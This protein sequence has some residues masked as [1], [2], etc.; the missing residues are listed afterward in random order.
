[1]LTV[2]PQ[3][4]IVSF[5]AGTIPTLIWLWF[6]VREEEKRAEP[7]GLLTAVFV[8]GMASVMF[9][10]PIQ[11]FIQNTIS[12]HEWQ[13]TLWAASEEII[14]YL[15]VVLVLYGT[16]EIDEP[17]DW[18]I[19]MITAGLGFAALENTFFLIKP[20]SLGDS[21]VGLLTG[22][23]RF[24]GSTLLHAIASAIIGISRALSF[25]LSVFTQ[26]LYMFLGLFIAIFLH[27]L[28]NFFIIESGSNSFLRVFAFIWVVAVIVMLMFEK[29]RRMS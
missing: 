19:Y 21:T 13:V 12:E 15:A 7:L 5:L 11:K 1:M 2:E 6:W 14:K 20:F 29:V 3:V 17:I 23:L 26:K 27:T 22:G 28:F 24:L 8:V 18:P 16:R 10:L 9:V 25:H 4:L